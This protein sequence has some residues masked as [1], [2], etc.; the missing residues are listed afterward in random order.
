MLRHQCYSYFS[1]PTDSVKQL[2]GGFYSCAAVSESG[3]SLARAEVRVL[4]SADRPPPI[5][6]LG[7]ANQTVKA[8]SAV[9]MPCQ[10][11]QTS[12][13]TI[14]WLKDGVPLATTMAADQRIAV[15]NDNTLVIE[16]R[17]FGREMKL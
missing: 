10:A 8:G 9:K 6:Q 4:T 12:G 1:P 7:P 16:G 15:E 17:N 11:T 5:I 13:Q 14:V 3:S 2:D